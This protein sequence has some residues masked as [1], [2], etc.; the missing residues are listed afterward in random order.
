MERDSFVIYDKDNK[1]VYSLWNQSDT[2]EFQTLSLYNYGDQ[3]VSVN[4]VKKSA[5]PSVTVNRLDIKE[6]TITLLK[7]PKDNS[8]H[9]II[10]K[11]TDKLEV[12]F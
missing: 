12:S 7:T 2:N 10:N 5:I 8:V 9:L 1:V 6:P 3:L 4:K 11:Q